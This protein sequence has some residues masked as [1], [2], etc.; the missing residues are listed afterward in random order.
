MEGGGGGGG[1]SGSSSSSSNNS[2]SNNDSVFRTVASVNVL[3]IGRIL[4]LS[5]L[6]VFTKLVTFSSTVCAAGLECKQHG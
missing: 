5:K 6:P 2:N 1:G 4:K 3:G